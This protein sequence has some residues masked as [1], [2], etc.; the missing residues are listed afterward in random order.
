MQL[1]RLNTINFD[2]STISQKALDIANK[3]R[4]NL[5]PWKGQFSPQ[6]IQSLLETYS[7]KTDKILDPFAGSGTV[8]YESSLMN[9]DAIGIELNP[10]AVKMAQIYLLSSINMEERQKYIKSIEQKINHTIFEDLPLFNQINISNENENSFKLFCNIKNC[11][12]KKM[13]LGA[14]LI[15]E[16]YL[17]LLDPKEQKLTK[18]RARLIWQKLKHLIIN[19][20]YTNSKLRVLHGDCRK[21]PLKKNSIDLI[22]TSPPYINV[23]NYHQQKRASIEMMGWDILSI[24]KSEIGSNRKHRSNRYFTV[25]Q[26]CLDMTMVLYELNRICKP[27][28]KLIFIIGRE[29]NVKKTIF[30]NSEIIASIA[31][32]VF[33][34]NIK[35][36]HERLFKNRYG[37]KIKEDL[38]L[39]ENPIEVLRHGVDPKQIAHHV[40]IEA[41]HRVPI[42]EKKALSI[43]IESIDLIEPSPIY[44]SNNLL[45]EPFYML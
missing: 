38:L 35:C 39:F 25:I 22:I 3:E 15:L 30:F 26:Y 21:T 44:K 14:Q 32:Q 41:S 36:R 31:K 10:A 12:N 18:A 27:K 11:L 1:I 5:L 13:A 16:T 29:S 7:K 28:A 17:I 33:G 20:P 24:A 9:L 42:K 19:L 2:N 6:L 4:S 34:F 8:L 23:F 40:L 43:A 37:Q 45:Q